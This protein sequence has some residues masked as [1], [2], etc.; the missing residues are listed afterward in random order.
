MSIKKIA[1]M[2]GTSPA[3]VS[4]VL[5]NPNYKCSV[6]GL[7]E[8]I[9]KTAM[10]LNYTPNEAARSLKCGLGKAS[11]KKYVIDV[12]VTRMNG[13]H[14]D[15]FFEELLRVVESQIHENACIL[16]RV[17]YQSDFSDDSKV[18]RIKI[19]RCLKEMIEQ[20]DPV[21]NGLIIIGRCSKLVIERLRK[22]YKNIVSINRNSTNYAVDEVLCDGKKIAS[23]AIEHLVRLGHNKIAY[24]GKCHGEARYQGYMEVLRKNSIDFYPEY[25]ID[26]DQTEQ[27][28][29]ETM[30]NFLKLEEP[31]TGIYCA[32]DILAVGMIKCLNQYKKLLYMPSIISSDDIEEGQYTRPMLSTVRLPKENMAK[33]A[34]YLL[35]DRMQGGH[36]E[37]VRIE[38]EGKLLV[39]NSCSPV[40][41]V[42]QPEY[43]I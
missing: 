12:L 27:K 39:R 13:A 23:L 9:W 17:W 2:T 38:L 6:E 32:N 30:Q 3:T 7:R 5:N 28:G 43:C 25:V 10:E 29:F 35:L 4:R 15:P 22:F 33:F 21:Y 34:V 16:S 42:S 31:P 41:E 36:N 11:K 20:V 18:E 19:D 37:V 40:D 1:A 24:V 14:A 26:V 8:K